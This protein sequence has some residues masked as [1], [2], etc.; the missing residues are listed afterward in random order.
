MD[1]KILGLKLNLLIPFFA[2]IFKYTHVTN[3]LKFYELR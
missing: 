1:F 3:Y 2:K